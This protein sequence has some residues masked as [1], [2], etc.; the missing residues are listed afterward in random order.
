MRYQSTMTVNGYQT[1]LNYSFEQPLIRDNITGNF[2]SR[3]EIPA[4]TI[5]EQFSPLLGIQATMKN[6][7]TLNLNFKKS[8]NLRLNLIAN[9]ELQEA[10][11]LD[12]DDAQRSFNSLSEAMAENGRSRV[13]LG[14]HFDFDAVVHQ[15]MDEH[16][17]ERSLPFALGVE[18]ADAY[19]A[20][21]PVFSF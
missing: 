8:R 11:G 9:P 3:F 19:E 20:M 17:S 10:Y 7:M 12:L 5:N 4:L 15:W 21:Y 1:N 16:R 6:D 14:I 13:Y 2:Y 18:R